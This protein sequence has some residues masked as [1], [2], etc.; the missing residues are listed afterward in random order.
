MNLI[1]PKSNQ[2]YKGANAQHDVGAFI[3]PMLQI[4]IDNRVHDRVGGNIIDGTKH[5]LQIKV[6]ALW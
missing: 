5:K 4:A 2:R 1:M 6:G 3:A